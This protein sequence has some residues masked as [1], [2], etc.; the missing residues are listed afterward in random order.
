MKK[1]MNDLAKETSGKIRIGTQTT[2][3]EL[4]IREVMP[5]FR[6]DFPNV[7]VC[8]TEDVSTRIM[9]RVR[10]YE[11]DAAITTRPPAETGFYT[12]PI[13]SLDQILLVPKEHSLV[14]RAV[15]KP[16]FSHPWVDLEWCRGEHFILMH[17]GQHPRA[18]SDAILAP[19]IK[20]IQIVLE[21]RNLRSMIEAVE[22]RIGITLSV[23]DA[24]IL[25]A[26]E[27][28]DLVELSYGDKPVNPSTFWLYY[29]QEVYRT[30]ALEHFLNLTREVCCTLKER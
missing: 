9:E 21:V 24:D 12:E 18:L 10:A 14:K 25:Y 7:R 30:K 29:R 26:S 8:L 4:L 15:L 22:Q 19:I 28:D 1:E 5:R 27:W 3:V 6:E 2:F 20:D 11:L 16:E 23:S 13:L 17:P